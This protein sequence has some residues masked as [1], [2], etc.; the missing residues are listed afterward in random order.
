MKKVGLGA[1]VV[2][3]TLGIGSAA[4]AGSKWAGD[5]NVNLTTRV[6]MANLGSARNSADSMQHVGCDV[7]AQKGS[8]TLAFCY[9][10]DAAGVSMSCT[11]TS[12][13]FVARAR[14]LAS[15]T[16]LN[17]FW[18]ASGACTALAVENYSVYEPM[19]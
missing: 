1:L 4:F 16:L 15:A 5:V 12:P 10:R 8:A 14:S 13:A 9:A 7:I 11:T 18:D 17:L 2:I 19:L 6:V 3:G